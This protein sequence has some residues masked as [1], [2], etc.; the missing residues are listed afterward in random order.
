MVE[1]GFVHTSTTSTTADDLQLVSAA[2]GF[3][4]IATLAPNLALTYADFSLI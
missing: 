3:V 1:A 2:G 4:H